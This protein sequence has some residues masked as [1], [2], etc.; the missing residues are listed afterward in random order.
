MKVLGLTLVILSLVLILVVAIYWHSINNDQ[1]E[2]MTVSIETIKETVEG[3]TKKERMVFDCFEIIAGRN[4]NFVS[5]SDVQDYLKVSENATM[6]VFDSLVEKDI[7]KGEHR[8]RANGLR[9]VTDFG[10]EC[11][12]YIFGQ[13]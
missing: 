8:D 13:E 2:N 10:A 9:Y 5:F 3:L 11:W 1:G 7:I 12:N 6:A 4:D